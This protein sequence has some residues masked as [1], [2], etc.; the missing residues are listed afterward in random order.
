MK[1]LYRYV[2]AIY[3]PSL[4]IFVATLTLIFASLDLSTKLHLFLR[5]DRTLAQI[6]EYY[7]PRLPVFVLYLLPVSN[8]FAAAFTI[9]R[10]NRDNE[11]IPML[12]S[13]VSIRKICLLVGIYSV[14]LAAVMFVNENWLLPDLS[15]RLV[16]TSDALRSQTV[17]EFISGVTENGSLIYASSYDRREKKLINPR[18]IVRDRNGKIERIIKAQYAVWSRSGHW[19][20]YD[21]EIEPFENGARKLENVSGDLVLVTVPFH[22]ERLKN[23]LVPNPA[24]LARKFS[25]FERFTTIE[26]SMEHI[27]RDPENGFY[28]VQLFSKF[29]QPTAVIFLAVWAF[30]IIMSMN[31][32]N[33]LGG[34]SVCFVTALS[35]QGI[36]IAGLEIGSRHASIAFAAVFGP[37]LAGIIITFLLL[38]KTKT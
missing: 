37:V 4:L 12:V 36:S 28:K 22:E 7:L 31:M 13:G 6:C 5:S 8:M 26:N 27:E 20:V 30:P 15:D 9:I 16:E 2:S 23:E 34:L 17:T 11:L 32:R 10:L 35:Y 24:D 25:V 14:I 21:G 38:W 3:V 29:S 18:F 19:K 1:L 33:F